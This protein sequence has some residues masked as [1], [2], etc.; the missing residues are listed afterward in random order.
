MFLNIRNVS[1]HIF[2]FG[3]FHCSFLQNISQLS[4]HYSAA[5][6]FIHSV[7]LKHNHLQKYC[8][9]NVDTPNIC[10]KDYEV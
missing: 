4:S 6:I 9:N 3:G 1:K 7:Y 5:A 2:S 8:I 10:V